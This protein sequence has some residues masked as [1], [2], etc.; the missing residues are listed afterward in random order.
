VIETFEF[1]NGVSIMP[2]SVHVSSHPF[3]SLIPNRAAFHVCIS[4]LGDQD[5]YYS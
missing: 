3:A 2:S 1:P 5:S 4:F